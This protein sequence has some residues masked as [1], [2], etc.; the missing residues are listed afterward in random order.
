MCGFCVS[1]H[2]GFADAGQDI[3]CAGVS[4]ALQLTANG[5]TEV[6]GEPAEVT[7]GD[8]EIRL[9][10]CGRGSREASCFLEAFRLQLSLLAED[11]PNTIEITDREV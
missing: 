9:R 6:L 11:Y 7:V 5:I 2:A 1:G 8:N 3:V 10:L 4:S